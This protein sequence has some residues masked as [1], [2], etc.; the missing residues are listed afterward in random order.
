MSQKLLFPHFFKKIGWVILIP[1][2]L[3]G[4][5]SHITSFELLPLNIKVFAFISDEFFSDTQYFSMV[6]TNVGPTLTGILFII[7][8][9]LVAFSKEKKEDEY[10]TELRL[11]SLMWAVS[12]NYILLFLAFLFVYGMPFHTV[13]IYNMFTVIIIF[14]IRFH[15]I[16][17]KNFK[18]LAD[19]K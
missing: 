17:Y 6:K 7:G 10:I 16:L 2:T 3:Y 14:I 8:A 19:E 4:I 1:I 5:F 12:V 11:S 9:M 18:L 13:M 15:F